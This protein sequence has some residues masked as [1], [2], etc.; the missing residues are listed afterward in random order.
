MELPDELRLTPY[1]KRPPYGDGFHDRLHVSVQPPLT[2]SQ[3]MS[4]LP[5]LCNLA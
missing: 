5:M 3:D 4:T 2:A 1:G